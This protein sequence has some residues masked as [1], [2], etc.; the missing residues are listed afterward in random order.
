MIVKV[1]DFLAKVEKYG[2]TVLLLAALMICLYSIVA[3]SSGLSTGAWVPK[4]IQYAVIWSVFFAAGAAL[5]EN[6]HLRVTLVID[7]VF[8]NFNPRKR[9]CE[10]AVHVI[11]LCVCLVVFAYCVIGIMKMQATGAIDDEFFYWPTYI[12]V[13]SVPLGMSLLSFHFIEHIYVLL[14]PT[15]SEASQTPPKEES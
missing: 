3:R 13:I 8:P 4:F 5:K 10:L 12:L 15:S 1:G 11:G 6:V 7:R 2:A 9:L 14:R